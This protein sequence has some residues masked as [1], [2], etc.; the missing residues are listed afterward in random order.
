MQCVCLFEK[1]VL[2]WFPYYYYLFCE[3]TISKQSPAPFPQ[4]NKRKPL[5]VSGSTLPIHPSIHSIPFIIYSFQ[6][7]PNNIKILSKQ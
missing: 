5:L 1:K 2:V 6:S 7:S 3:R 4:K